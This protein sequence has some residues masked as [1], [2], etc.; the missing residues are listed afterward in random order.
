MDES[1]TEVLAKAIFEDT[2]KQ[3]DLIAKIYNLGDLNLSYPLSP[4]GK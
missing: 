2:K 1:Q 3:V 4:D